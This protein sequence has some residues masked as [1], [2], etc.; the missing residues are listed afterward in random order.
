[1]R[2]VPVG[3]SSWADSAWT[4][5]DPVCASYASKS[6]VWKLPKDQVKKTLMSE[7][8]VYNED[9]FPKMHPS[10]ALSEVDSRDF[11]F[12]MV[13]LRHGIYFYCSCC[14][15]GSQ[16]LVGPIKECLWKWSI[17]LIMLRVMRFESIVKQQKEKKPLQHSETIP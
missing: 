2:D 6:T 3:W 11:T 13:K 12:R 10:G 7:G 8:H 5:V 15:I 1:M 16:V 4:G 9:L 14:E 17:H